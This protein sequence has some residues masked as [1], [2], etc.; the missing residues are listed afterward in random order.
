MHPDN[1]ACCQNL[2]VAGIPPT[3][4]KWG[5][6]TTRTIAGLIFSITSACCRDINFIFSHGG[7]SVTSLTDRFSVLLLMSP[8]YNPSR[9]KA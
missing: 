6:D 2:A 9:A 1:P 3:I 4:I 5:T 7:G 8:K